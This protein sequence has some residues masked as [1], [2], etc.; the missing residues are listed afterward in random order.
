MET[1]KA[2]ETMKTINATKGEL[3]NVINGLFSVQELKGK[4]FSLLVS[5]NIKILQDA[6]KDI[7]NAGKPSEEF[8]KLAEKVNSIATDNKEDAKAEIDQLEKDNKELV[9]ARRKQ[10]ENAQKMM[11]DEISVDLHIISEDILPEEVTAQQISKML[12]II[13]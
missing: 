11:E 9:D 13:E 4:S 5:K 10:M 3:V 12:K 8:M 1:I 6:L 2:I 7:E